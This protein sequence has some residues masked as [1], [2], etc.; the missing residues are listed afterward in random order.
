MVLFIILGVVVVAA[1]GA[2]GFVVYTLSQEAQKEKS[3][4]PV[5]DLKQLKDELSFAVSALSKQDV[6]AHEDEVIPA[7]VPKESV[8]LLSPALPS[9]PEVPSE[10]QPAPLE[11]NASKKRVQ[12]LEE[13]LRTIKQEAEQQADVTR[14]MILN[15]SKENQTLKSQQGQPEEAQ[16][17]LAELEGQITNLKAENESLQT[18]KTQQAETEGVRQK[19]VELEGQITNLKAENESLQ[20][21][22]TQQAETEEVR[23]KLAELEGQISNLKAENERLQTQLESSNSAVSELQNEKEALLSAP[24]PGPDEGSL[25]LK[26]KCEGLEYELIKARAQSSG[27]ERVSFNYKN[28]LEDFLKKV[29]EVQVTNEQLSQTKNR[30]EGLVEE[31]K[32]QNEE[33]V[34]KDQLTQFELE[35]NRS[36]LV[37]LEREYEDFK[38]RVQQQN[39]Q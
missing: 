24:K 25:V 12:E 35:K 20:M 14:D 17:K 30:L 33:L 19:L 31:I 36:R 37:N 22:K 10:V 26:Q 15:L 29:N 8:E 39:Q 21:L 1:F 7:F 3:A 23:Q 27:L 9:T 11:D 28:Q 13:E 18:L 38:A 16:Q 6:S 5:T 2:L 32:S 4:V 34:K